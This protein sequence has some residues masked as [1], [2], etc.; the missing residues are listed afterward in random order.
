MSIS[1]ISRL[2]DFWI[3]SKTNDKHGRNLLYLFLVSG[4]L[5]RRVINTFDPF[6]LSLSH[7]LFAL[8]S[9]HHATVS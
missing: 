7:R 5:D 6:D 9:L 2:H 1:D 8:V 3:Q 4:R